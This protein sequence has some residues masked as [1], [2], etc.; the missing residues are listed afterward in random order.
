[1]KAASKGKYIIKISKDKYDINVV[2]KKKVKVFY[3]TVFI[4]EIESI[5]TTNIIH[6]LGYKLDEKAPDYL[7][8]LS[9]LAITIYEKF[10]EKRVF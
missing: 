8:N 4:D 7:D 2:V 1:M 5:Y 3:R 10:V 9:D 6:N